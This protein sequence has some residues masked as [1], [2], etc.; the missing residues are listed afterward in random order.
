[1]DGKGERCEAI[2]FA[3]LSPFFSAAESFSRERK[4]SNGF[5]RGGRERKG[6]IVFRAKSDWTAKMVGLGR[7]GEGEGKKRK[8]DNVVSRVRLNGFESAS[9]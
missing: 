6:G 1:M 5:S 8:R 2:L 4:A 7:E 9:K 3:A